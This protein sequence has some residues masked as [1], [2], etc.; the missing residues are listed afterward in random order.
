MR[1]KTM[2]DT[3][4]F[5]GGECKA[6]DESGR[7]GGY[8]VRYGSP[9]QPDGS[10][11]RDYF[12]PETDF[13]VEL[14]AKTVAIYHH[15]LDPK[16]GL[17]KLGGVE[18]KADD[19]GVWAE[20]QLKIRD[21]YERKIHDM[22]RA[23]KLGWSSGSASH[24]IRREKQANGSHKVLSWPIAEASLTP[25]PAEPRAQAVSLKSLLDDPDAGESFLAACLKSASD[26]GEAARR[27]A[28][29]GNSKREAIKS[30]RD[31]L[32]GLLAASEPRPDP[33]DVSRS[34]S[35]FLATEA[36]LRGVK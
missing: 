27:F 23:G 32:D 1:A 30:L 2:N 31:T 25:A 10:S 6:L 24:L 16:L 20:A 22:V 15:G 5:Y 14:P 4:V 17:R 26:L 12:T 36:R 21:D 28:K 35:R 13:W 33:A 29:L 3:L 19:V 7:I 34:Y 9:G 11:Y 8:L 18:L